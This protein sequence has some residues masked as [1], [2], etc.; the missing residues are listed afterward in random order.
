MRPA[1][2]CGKAAVLFDID[3]VNEIKKRI[4]L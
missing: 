3:E 2:H 4:K 1:K